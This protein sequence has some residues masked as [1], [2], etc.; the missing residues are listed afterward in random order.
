MLPVH[1][2]NLKKSVFILSLTLGLFCFTT[3]GLEKLLA[4]PS[5]WNQTDWSGGVGSSTASQYSSASNI[6]VTTT[7]GQAVL[8][9]A[10]EEFTNTDFESDLS[11]WSTPALPTGGTITTFGDYRIHTFTSSGTFT[12]SSDVY[13]EVLVVAG[14]GSGGGS[15]AGGGGAGGLIYNASYAVSSGS[16]T[17]TVGNGGSQADQQTTG[18]SGQNSV[19][20]ALTAI[21]GG[22]GGFTSASTNGGPGLTGG[23]G[24]GGA[25]YGAKTNSQGTGT[26]G[27]GND[28]GTYGTDTFPGGGGGGAGT[29]GA[30]PTASKSG[31]GGAGLSYSISGSA[32]YY[33]GGGVGGAQTSGGNGGIGGGGAGTSN[34][35]VGTAGTPNTGGGGGGGWLYSGGRGGAGGSGI[36]VIRYLVSSATQDSDIKY[37][38]N[39]SAKLVSGNNVQNFTQTVN[40]GD[41]NE[42]NLYAYAY[43]DGST[44][45]DDTYAQLY[46]NG[47]AVTTSYTHVGSGW[48]KLSAVVT[49]ADASRQYGVQIKA[50]RTIYV[51]D[52]SLTR[53][54]ITGVLTSNI[55]DTEYPSDWGNLTYTSSGTGS[56]SVKVRTSNSATMEGATDWASCSA[57]V[58]GADLTGGCVTDAHRYVQY[59]VTLTSSGAN[60]PVFE[61]I[62]IAFS[63]SDQTKPPASDGNGSDIYIENLTDGT[64]TKNED[65]TFK[66][67]K[68]KDNTGGSGLLGYCVSLDEAAPDSSSSLD[69]ELTSGKLTGLNDGVTQ[70]YCPFIV[71]DEVSGEVSFDLSNISGLT[72]TSGK[73]YYLSLKAVD[74]AGNIWSGDSID[75][76][77]LA[78]FKYDNTPPSNVSYISAP[79]I[80]FGSVND[81][82]FSWPSTV[83]SAS[84]DNDSQV[85]GWQY[86]INSTNTWKGTE[87]HPTLDIDYMPYLGSTYS[88]TLTEGDD[89]ASVVVGNNTIYL[90]TVDNAGNTSSY[91]T[92]GI[93]YGGAAPSFGPE[94]NVT[95]TPATN[96]SN[97]F[98]L[99][100][101]ESDP[102]EGREAE[103][104]YYM[105]NRLPPSTLATLTGNASLYIP[106]NRT[107]VAA[108]TMV[109]SIKGDNDVYVVSVDDENNYSPSNYITGT[110]TLD[111]TNPDPPRNLSV[112]DASV[113]ETEL[114]RASLTWQ[115]PAYKGNGSLTY[116]IERSTDNTSWDEVDT[117]TGLSY[118]DTVTTSQLYYYRV[119]VYDTSDE[120]EDD[121]SYTTSV[122]ITPQG[123]YT[124]AASLSSGPTVS[125]ITT[126][127]ATISWSTDRTSD[128]KISYG[129]KGSD[130][131]DEE[132]S[133]STQ[134]TDHEIALTNLKP[135]T[136]YYYK[137]KWTDEDGNTGLSDEKTFKT[138]PAPTAKEVRASNISIAS[139][140]IVFTSS[141]A[142]K[143]KIYYGKSTAFGSLYELSTSTSETTYNALLGGLEDGTKYYYRINL[144]DTEGEE[145]EGEID[146]FETLPR[147][148][149]SNIRV[150][151]VLGTAQPAMLVSWETNTEVSSIV[152]Y[153]PE[154]NTGGAKDEVEA[155][156]VKG[157]H[158]MV[159]RGLLPQTPYAVIVKGRDKIG[160][161]ALSDT[162]RITT[163]TDTRPPLVSSLKIQGSIIQAS[164]GGGSKDEQ[165]AQ[166]I[167]SW[168]TDEPATGQVEFGEG[169][170][171]TYAQKT[172]EDTN[173]TFNHSVVITGL[174]P[175]KVYHLKSVSKDKAGNTGNSVDT[176][177][178]APKATN[179]ALNLVITNLSQVFGFIG[180]IS[181]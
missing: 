47:G 39:A 86:A 167:V 13:V 81:M 56:V 126:R 145:Y 4:A 72:L 155:S 109:G 82:N 27:Q 61:D 76:Q 114:W 7:S 177:T 138:N 64:W 17:V 156:L 34:G 38:G 173:L 69:P 98:A 6:D 28:G 107:S 130:Y 60:T 29:V 14:G 158:N 33:A 124:E 23:S 75:Y 160:N 168:N 46:Y 63:A 8:S 170:S 5:P 57:K 85:L 88:Y 125:A 16:T 71:E 12:A 87:T 43:I 26:V 164:G 180:G 78:S 148:R 103:T 159:I 35:T 104:Y 51:D 113:K 3:F 134:T 21:G 55:L 142:S 116:I 153:Y 67:T 91:V 143:A 93:S 94:D 133:I 92:G 30:A 127:K 115:E 65:I 146:S 141:N 68:G 150:Q 1:R 84:S 19:F 66:W 121:P 59:Q 40:V 90:R 162:Q 112:T 151:Q 36:V 45:V 79:S 70:S 157:E 99:S 132:P 163:A 15:T 135:G 108:K 117:T 20:G 144:F 165:S 152:T 24:G 95:I 175:S 42:Y 174:T 53:Y 178:I 105:I 140:T 111:S 106:T 32:V 77:D 166:L 101:P 102:S 123:T 10:G 128:S 80:S 83:G 131:F 18:N 58:S 110:Y 161:E 31:N 54:E 97:S 11:S 48:Y 176:V 118:T 129:T 2:K 119:G 44:D 137:A 100:W 181:N 22:G 41:A 147:P 62:T 74:L 136:K 52:F 25:R 154:G 9:N 171:S 37:A 89:G 139:A 96:T 169:T 172:Q 122:S 49:G 50:N 179:N 149:I 120:S 73:Q